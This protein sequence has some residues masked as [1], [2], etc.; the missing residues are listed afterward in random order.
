MYYFNYEH[1]PFHLF[2]YYGWQS[3]V[4]KEK[5]LPYDF[6]PFA[7]TVT[8]TKIYEVDTLPNRLSNDDCQ[9]FIDRIKPQ[10]EDSLI[11]EY[12]RNRLVIII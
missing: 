7:Q 4:V 3:L 10:L 12:N 1:T 9:Q 2:R 5:I 11:F 6:L 8:K